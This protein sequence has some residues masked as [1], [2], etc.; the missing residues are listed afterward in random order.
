MD[1]S[2]TL[3]GFPSGIASPPGAVPILPHR[4]LLDD[5]GF[6]GDAPSLEARYLEREG[7]KWGMGPFACKLP[8]GSI[9]QQTESA[10]RRV[11]HIHP[12]LPEP[13][14]VLFR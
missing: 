7:G 4:L 2:F 10:E 8:G 6:I 12:N 3:I 1:A 5:L 13:Q 11:G 9:L 14:E